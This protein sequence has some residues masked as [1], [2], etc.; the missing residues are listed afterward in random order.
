MMDYPFKIG[1]EISHYNWHWDVYE[2]TLDE[3]IQMA[4][5]LRN[6]AKNIKDIQE[7]LAKILVSWNCVGR[8]GKPL[9][10][11]IEGI[12]QIPQSVL[13]EALNSLAKALQSG[14]SDPKPYT[15][16][17]PTTMP[18]PGETKII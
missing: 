4:E 9:T 10:P 16:S 11:D 6:P 3:S 5:L 8:D 12:K 17:S 7:M 13:F 14:F 15:A 1:L 18:S 2:P